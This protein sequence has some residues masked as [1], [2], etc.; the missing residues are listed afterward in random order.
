MK[1][2]FN[3]FE[4]VAGLFLL[5]AAIGTVVIGLSAAIK[6]GWF[7]P[8]VQF[9]TYFK[10]ADGIHQGTVVQ[11]SGL[12]AGSIESVELQ[13]DNTVKVN[14]YVLG[15]FHDRIRQDSQVQLLRP[16]VIGERVMEITVGS[17]AKPKLASHSILYSVETMDLMSLMSGRHMNSYLS[18]VGD[19]LESMQVLMEAFSDKSRAKSLV[20]VFDRMDPLVKNLSTMSQEVIT[21]S[22]QATQNDGVKNLVLNLTDTTKEINKILPE[23]NRQNPELAQDLG[24]MLKDLS[25]VTQ[26]LTPAVQAIQPELPD[27]SRRL[28]EALSETVIV[29]KAMQKSF[30]ME[31]NV[32]EVRTEEALKR[33][34]AQ[35]K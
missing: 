28:V 14:F 26:A 22:R 10:N 32:Q 20:R 2:K 6:Q 13:S 24:I 18:K 3:K 4:R 31:S 33:M 21:L 12:R 27:A 16:F 35:S 29:L 9:T 7:E 23:L 5:T 15:K 17:E 11:M 30:L 19:I 25:K 1:I 8:R 34:P